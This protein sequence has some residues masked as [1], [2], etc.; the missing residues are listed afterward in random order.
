MLTIILLSVGGA[1][2]A[3]ALGTFW[4]SEA[5]PMGR[6]HMKYLGMD[7]LS[8]EEK[9]AEIAKA[10]PQMPKIYAAQM[11]L[12]FL[13]AFA[14]VYILSVSVANGVSFSLALGFV[15]MNW[16]CFMVPVTGMNILWGNCPREIAWQK[17]FSEIGFTLV[18]L[19]LTAGLTS[20]FV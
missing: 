1:I 20:F 18:V 10:M 19:L 11:V 7:K 6:L 3:A 5:T 13:T 8:A 14:T 4:Y 16:L 9:K 12:S 15:L 2:L 17:F